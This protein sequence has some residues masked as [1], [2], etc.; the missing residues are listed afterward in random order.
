MFPANGEFYMASFDRSERNASRAAE[1]ADPTKGGAGGGRATR[2][3]LDR[4]GRNLIG[5]R[6][7]DSYASLIAEPIPPHLLEILDGQRRRESRT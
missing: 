3:F 6:L 4:R 7:R 2:P 1:N 5:Q